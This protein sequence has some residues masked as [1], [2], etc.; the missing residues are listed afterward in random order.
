M[1]VSDLIAP[2]CVIANLRVA[3]KQQALR[4]L[5]RR[6]ASLVGILESIAHDT[7]LARERLGS[8]G[9]GAGVA[10]P[11]A[12][13]PGLKG[14]RGVFARLERPVD[15]DAIDGR[16]VDLI[17]LVLVPE[18]AGS[19]HLAA[20]ACAA[21]ALRNPAIAKML[22]DTTESATLYAILSGQSAG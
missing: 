21:R 16:P 17:F 11:H 6:A 4:D 3:D 18:S 15:F 20:L 1:Q 2:E 22:R 10:V 8:T 19:E 13:I 5:A 14:V 9:V 7:L 12:R